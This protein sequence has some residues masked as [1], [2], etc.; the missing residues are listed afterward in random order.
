MDC[1]SNLADSAVASIPARKWNRHSA[2]LKTPGHDRLPLPDGHGSVRLRHP[3]G[4]RPT[5]PCGTPWVIGHVA[6]RC[7]LRNPAGARAFRLCSGVAS[8]IR[9]LASRRSTLLF[10]FQCFDVLTCHRA[11]AMKGREPIVAH[12]NACTFGTVRRFENEVPDDLPNAPILIAGDRFREMVCL[13]R[14]V[15]RGAHNRIMAQTHP[16]VILPAIPVSCTAR[17]KLTLDPN[18]ASPDIRPRESPSRPRQATTLRPPRAPYLR[19]S[20]TSR[21]EPMAGRTRSR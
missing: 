1:S 9:T 19:S 7:P 5:G 20:R 2:P 8:A 17:R 10:T 18:A 21:R 3:A 12:L 16:A 6:N 15:E 14:N 4:W 13:I 11:G